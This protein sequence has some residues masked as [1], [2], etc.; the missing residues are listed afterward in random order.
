MTQGV[1]SILTVVAI[2]LINAAYLDTTNTELVFGCQMS[3]MLALLIA[4]LSLIKTLDQ[5]ASL[6]HRNQDVS[7]SDL[8]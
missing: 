1:G 5:I 7:V 8:Q 6:Q 3:A 4:M 2:I